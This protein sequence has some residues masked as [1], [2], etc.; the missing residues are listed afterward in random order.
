MQV[1]KYLTGGGLQVFPKCASHTDPSSV[2]GCTQIVYSIITCTQQTATKYKTTSF[3]C[4]VLLIAGPRATAINFG[5]RR[6]LFTP[7]AASAGED[8]SWPEE[9]AE[10]DPSKVPIWCRFPHTNNNVQVQAWEN[11]SW[12]MWTRRRQWGRVFLVLNTKIPVLNYYLEWICTD[13]SAL[14]AYSPP[15][16]ITHKCCVC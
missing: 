10:A 14:W 5:R 6:W 15:P 13:M 16:F 7:T 11:P 4:F 12:R 1:P 8:G 9:G 3:A 2:C